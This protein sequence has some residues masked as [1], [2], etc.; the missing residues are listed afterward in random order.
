M[1]NKIIS[2]LVL[3]MVLIMSCNQVSFNSVDFN[4]YPIYSGND[5]GVTYSEKGTQ[6]KIWE[7]SASKVRLKLYEKG[8]GGDVL[9]SFLLKKGEKGLWSILIKKDIL[10]RYYTFQSNVNGKWHNE[11]PGSYA[12]AVGV[13][14]MR[15]MIVDLSKTNPDGWDMDTKP[16]LKSFS[17]IILYELHVRDYSIHKNSGIKNKGKFIAFTE[18]G[19]KSAEGFTTGIDHIKELGVTHV[20]L[21]PSFD[22]RSND[23]TKAD[24]PLYNWGYDPQNYNV[25]EGTYATD[26]YNGTVR[27]K[28]FKEMV[29]AFHKNGIRVILDV[30]YNHVGYPAEQSF[31]QIVPGYYFRHNADGS[32]SNASGCGN[33]TASERPMMR[34][35]MIESVKYWARE[36]HLDGFRFDLMGIHDIQTMN[37]LA[38]ELHT[39]D[40]TL[41]IYGEGWTAGDSPL[42]PKK[43]TT[44]ANMPNVYGI[45]AFSDD[46]RDG[47]K[48]HWNNLKTKGFV[49]GEPDTEE[50]IKFGIVAATQHPQVDYQKVNYSKKYW[51]N[52][53]QQ[54]INYVSCHDN[55][56]LWDKLAISSPKSSIEER[57]R[58]AKMANTIVMTSQGVPF[59]HAGVEFLRSKQNVE[60]SFESPDSINWIDWSLKEKNKD[61]F[62]Y[63]QSLIQLRKEHP[64]FKMPTTDMISTHLEFM[65]LEEGMVG[66]TISG[67]ANG[68][69]W[70][71]ILVVFNANMESKDIDLGDEPWTIALDIEK[72]YR[73][74]GKK[75]S[76]KFKLEPLTAYVLYK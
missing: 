36:Y 32:F 30:V 66:Y 65:D 64:A 42:P 15:A 4:S 24:I 41:F 9:E 45:A 68:D 53:P 58:M 5:L 13:N 39:M 50:S 1:K 51:S 35:Y 17:D 20:H 71:T 11:V 31:E 72:G 33:E 47:I 40:S 23:E 19:T 59:L 8:L 49:S 76:G 18:E 67:N 22:Y 26:P 27:I 28:E 2:S 61:I 7:P 54:T 25:P 63:H 38:E 73:K 44:K 56:T 46:I 52:G 55:N 16:K 60:N 6:F 10:G 57:L 43:R 48:G 74:N 75:N 37:L 29:Q 3:L 34:K 21:L 70:N 62:V 12:K 69:S 14:G